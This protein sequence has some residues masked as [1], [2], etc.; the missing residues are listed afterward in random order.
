MY[1]VELYHSRLG[2]DQLADAAERVEAIADEM[3]RSGTLVRYLRT[4]F[5][6]E[7]ETCFYLFEADSAEAVAEVTNRAELPFE[8]VV[9]AVTHA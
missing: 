7:D 8:R 5:V 6:P 4:I 3:S 9:E 2:R 1:L